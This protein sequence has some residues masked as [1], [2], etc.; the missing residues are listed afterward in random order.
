MTAREIVLEMLMQVQEQEKLSHKVLAKGLAANPDLTCADKALAV[1]IFQGTLERKRTLDWII[2]QQAG[3][4]MT[5]MKPLVRNLLRMGAYQILFLEQV[6]NSAA[7]NEAVN[8]IKKR[9]MIGLS[10]FVNGVLRGI[11][12]NLDNYPD[13]ESFLKVFSEDMTETERLGFLYSMPDWLVIYWQRRYPK[14]IVQKMLAAF[15]ENP[16]LS[17]HH[18]VS[19]GTLGELKDALEEDGVTF[20]PGVYADNALL[21]RDVGNP[22]RLRAFTEGRFTVQDES[23]ILAGKILPL[24]KGMTVLDLCAAPGG[25]AMHAADMLAALGGGRVIA[26]DLTESKVRM[27]REQAARIGL[28]NVECVVW[29]ARQPNPALKESVDLVLADL[30]CSGL[31]V[32]GRKPDIRWKTE[33]EDILELARLQK[34][35]LFTAVSYVKPGGYLSYSTCTLTKEENED[36]VEYLQSLGMELCDISSYLPK[37]LRTEKTKQG[38]LTLIPGIQKTDGFFASLLKKPAK[39]A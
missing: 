36:N 33:Y 21:L 20:E 4:P 5:K 19:R 14:D 11:A 28:D 7:C 29:D 25:K 18:N 13:T 37:S 16:P 35:I 38:Q 6:P 26:G 27:V 30:P 15:L 32:I 17:I 1:R 3:R 9:G 31:G 8:L 39:N 22:A 12:R 34:E 10:G 24:K 23:S 2:E